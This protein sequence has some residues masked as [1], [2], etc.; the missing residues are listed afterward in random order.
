M[1]EPIDY[2]KDNGPRI[3]GIWSGKIEIS[4]DFDELP[5]SLYH[6]FFDDNIQPELEKKIK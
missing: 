3:L 1:K 5:E 6:A 2:Q 4:E